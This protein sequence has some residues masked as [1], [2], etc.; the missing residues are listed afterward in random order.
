MNILLVDD[1][2]FSRDVLSFILHDHGYSCLEADSG[3]QACSM[4]SQNKDIDLVLM[5]VNMPGMGGF[6][7]AQRI[8]KEFPNRM[9]PIIFVT[10]M[11]DDDMLSSCLD[12][13]GDDFITKPVRETVLIS[14]INA[15]KR[16]VEM[17]DKLEAANTELRYHQRMLDR[18]HSIVN[19]IFQNDMKRMD[20]SISNV[21]FHTSPMSM[22]NGDLLLMTRSPSGG[23]YAL[24]GDFTGHGLAASIGYL[25][26]SDI[27]YNLAKQQASVEDIASA[28]NSRLR[29]MLPSNM[30]L[31]ASIIEMNCKG[32]SF[33][34]WAGGM[35]DM[36][37]ID[38]S[39]KFET[40]ICSQNMPLAILDSHEFKS[41][42]VTIQPSGYASLFVYTDGITEA[43]NATGE[44]YGE[45]R[46]ESILFRSSSRSRISAVLDDLG[47][48]CEDSD[49]TDDMSMLEIICMPVEDP[50]DRHQENALSLGAITDC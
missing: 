1:Q 26:T 35:N 22:F 16:L 13:G 37:L 19:H 23:I 7:A 14:K 32:D 42:T 10:A 8:K 41:R 17:H 34:I 24:L 43:T 40:R 50:T 2:K 44:Y 5:D 36:I 15:H 11:D 31:C 20:S 30:F 39:R 48:F 4:A 47:A 27:F 28:I 29:D 18:E 12:S 3:A 49:V 6:E 25:P 21:T 46:L 9:I 33:T 38:S 45:S